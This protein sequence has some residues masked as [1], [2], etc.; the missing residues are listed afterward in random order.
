M[1]NYTQYIPQVNSTTYAVSINDCFTQLTTD[2]T[3]LENGTFAGNINL[4]GDTITMDTQK[5]PSS[6]S[7]TGTKGDI[8]HDT[9]YI[10]VCTATN[11]WKRTA[12]ATW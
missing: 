11:T 12:I 8:V 2:V 10:Y 5:T 9:N 1:A 7:A 6:A 3:A 4:A